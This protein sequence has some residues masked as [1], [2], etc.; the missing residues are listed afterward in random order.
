M[1]GS[2][3]KLHENYDFIFLIT[4]VLKHIQNS[5][6]KVNTTVSLSNQLQ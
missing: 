5:I 1:S 4:E 3:K 6:T 2:L